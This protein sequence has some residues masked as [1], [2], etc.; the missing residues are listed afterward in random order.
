MMNTY[1]LGLFLCV[2]GAVEAR[3]QERDVNQRTLPSSVQELKKG[4]LN[5]PSESRP[6]VR[7]WWSNNQIEIEQV[8]KELDAFKA[9]GIGGVEINPI[10]DPI[11]SRKRKKLSKAPVLKWM[12]PEWKQVLLQTAQ[13]AKERGLIVDLLGGSGWPFGGSFL[14]DEDTAYRMV[15]HY[16]E[17]E[18][19]GL[20]EVDLKEVYKRRRSYASKHYGKPRSAKEELIYIK[21]FPAELSDLNE[22]KDISDQYQGEDRL[23]IEV[24]EGKHVIAYGVLERGF[25]FTGNAVTGAHGAA[26]NHFSKSATKNYLDQIF[27]I[28]DGWNEP[29]SKHVRAIFSDSVEIADA[30]FTPGMLERFRQE[31]GYDI[32]PYLALVLMPEK[33]VDKALQIS[34]DLKAN[35]RRARYDWHKFVVDTFI[36]A[37]P[38]TLTDYADEKAVMIRYQSGGNPA[39]MGIQEGSMIAHLPEAENWLN[40]QGYLS[41]DAFHDHAW[42]T[43]TLNVKYNTTAAN[44]TGK[45]IVSTESMTNVLDLFQV[46]LAQIKQAIDMTFIGGLNHAV[47]HGATYSPPDVE[48]PGLIRFGS[49]FSPNNT[50]WPYFRK[51]SDYTSRLSYMFQNSEVVAEVAILGPTPD[52]WG[53]SSLSKTSLAMTPNYLADLWRS[54]SELGVN[55]DYLHGDILKDAK[56]DK[57]RIEYGPMSYQML[58]VLEN[59]SMEPEVAEAIAKFAKTGGKVVYV[60]EPPSRSPSMVQAQK[61]DERVQKAT[62]NA[63]AKGAQLAKPPI[64]PKSPDQLRKWLDETLAA[65]QYPRTLRP[66]EPKAGIHTLRRRVGDEELI[67]LTNTYRNQPFQGKFEY[68]LQGKGLWHWEPEQG[69]VSPYDRPYEDSS[70]QVELGPLESI[71]LVTGTKEEAAPRKSLYQESSQEVILKAPWTVEFAPIEE[72]EPFVEKMTELSGFDQHQD[73]RIQKFSGQATYTN[74]FEWE[75]SAEAVLDLGDTNDSVCEIELNGK[76]V[77]V[78]WYGSKRFDVGKYLVPGKNTLKIKYTTTLFNGLQEN[79]IFQ[80]LWDI[81]GKHRKEKTRVLQASG[82]LGPVKLLTP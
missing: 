14:K 17:V 32:E 76:P 33:H 26:L 58:L 23:S 25:R 62:Q 38:Q 7:W 81:W 75:G 68:P 29:L 34:D 70:F 41:H 59:D 61:S 5:P 63:M 55:C 74:E 51:W 65:A 80:H 27:Q 56:V 13:K 15:V 3:A 39:F 48:Y 54:F 36:E 4:F 10:L 79:V 16:D 12:S 30:N 46:T 35:L 6:F 67:F 22:I 69:S 73:P 18:G 82:L 49:F 2:L 50:W 64:D 53:E 28:D 47:L 45:R 21:Q 20:H 42:R 44:L 57:G 52:V 77:G 71:L 40:R 72:G 78:S 19:P 60:G 11:N 24:P 37:F 43:H 66:S 31:K 9:A 1:Y 8:E